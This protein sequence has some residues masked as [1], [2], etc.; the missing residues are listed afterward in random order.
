MLSIHLHKIITYVRGIGPCKFRLSQYS[1]NYTKQ[2][3]WD[4]SLVPEALSLTASLKTQEN[5]FDQL[6][7]N[8]QV[9]YHI[10][11]YTVPIC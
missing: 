4:L 3:D 11:T 7:S 1:D 9:R 10:P 6:H 8:V 5:Q 2:A